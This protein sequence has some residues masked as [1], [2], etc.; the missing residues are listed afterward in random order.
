MYADL[1]TNNKASAGAATVDH[2]HITYSVVDAKATKILEDQK[3]KVPAKK[4]PPL[5]SGRY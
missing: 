1:G 4:T 3:P 5:P 2:H